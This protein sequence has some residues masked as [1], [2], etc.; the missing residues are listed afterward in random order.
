[1]S[2]GKIKKVRQISDFYLLIIYK[3]SHMQNRTT[4]SKKKNNNVDPSPKNPPI[5]P[6]LS[7]LHAIFKPPK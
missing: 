2:Y 5:P 6:T 7:L 4:K 1:M 3:S